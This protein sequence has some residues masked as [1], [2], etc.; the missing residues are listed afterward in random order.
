MAG[1]LNGGD[2]SDIQDTETYEAESMRTGTMTWGRRRRIGPGKSVHETQQLTFVPV[3]RRWAFG[4]LRTC[5][6]SFT[7]EPRDWAE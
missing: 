5:Q 2:R 4:V 7:C 1:I 3:S 6:G